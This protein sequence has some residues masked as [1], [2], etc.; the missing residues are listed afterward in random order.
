MLLL[1][2]SLPLQIIIFFILL[3]ELGEF[4]FF[5]QERGL[6]LTNGRLRMI[7]FKT[8]KTVKMEDARGGR[9]FL[10]PVDA[11][12]V[13]RFAHL[14]RRT[15][16]DELPQ[17]LHVMTGKMDLVGPRPLMIKDI[18]VMSDSFP[19]HYTIRDSLSS[20]PGI[21]G[22]W[23]IIGDRNSGIDNL[24]ALDLFYE[25]NKSFKLDIQILASTLPVVL[26]AKNNDTNVSRIEFI[27]RLFSSSTGEF[28]FDKSRYI[29]NPKM[30][31]G[32]YRLNL[33]LSWFKTVSMHTGPARAENRMI[34]IVETED[35]CKKP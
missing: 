33:P 9:E 35:N 10:I 24:L 6:T 25:E 27:N 1:I 13:T 3:M 19:D 2:L 26:F 11:I 31:T 5:V 23:Q 17:F 20:K 32:I 4:P 30:K 28:I 22:L 18:E 7:K 16:L 15:G 29:V 14:L 8:L 21:T 34:E 12:H